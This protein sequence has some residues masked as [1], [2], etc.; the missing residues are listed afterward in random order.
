MIKRHDKNGDGRIT[1]SEATGPLA[2]RFVQADRNSNGEL[3]A[4]EL[5]A[6]TKRLDAHLF[7]TP[8][9]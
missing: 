6:E 1:R 3:D 4:T 5:A 7:S 8:T 2:K 9:Y